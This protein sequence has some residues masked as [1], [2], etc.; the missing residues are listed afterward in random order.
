M[1]G[2]VNQLEKQVWGAAY[3]SVLR[4]ISDDI[5]YMLEKTRRVKLAIRAADKAVLAMRQFIKKSGGL[6]TDEDLEAE[7][8]EE[9]Q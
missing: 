1:V 9:E 2:S 7:R 8:L 4:P 5:S 6:H 3:A